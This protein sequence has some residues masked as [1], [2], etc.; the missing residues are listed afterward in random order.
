MYV[1]GWVGASE[2]SVLG[3][4][5]L[6]SGSAT[7]LYGS[8]LCA[9][10]LTKACGWLRACGGR[11]PQP[12]GPSHRHLPADWNRQSKSTS[13]PKVKTTRTRPLG[14]LGVGL[15]GGIRVRSARGETSATTQKGAFKDASHRRVMT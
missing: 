10:G 14:E 4:V 6:A 13:G 1:V 3:R 15:E 8:G 12:D 9:M 5:I 11:E 7:S 2:G